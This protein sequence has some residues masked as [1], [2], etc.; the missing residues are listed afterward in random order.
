MANYMEQ[1]LMEVCAKS[2]A[3]SCLLNC[4]YARR[5]KAL[6]NNFNTT[7]CELN[8]VFLSSSGWRSALWRSSIGLSSSAAPVGEDRPCSCHALQQ[9]H[10][11]GSKKAPI[12]PFYKTSSVKVIGKNMYPHLFI[13][14]SCSVFNP[15]QVNFYADHTKIIL[16]KSSDDS[17]LLTYISRERVSYTYLLSMLNEMGCTSELRHRLRYVVQLLQHHADAWEHSSVPP[18][19]PDW[20]DALEATWLVTTSS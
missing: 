7:C 2:L 14:H 15:F 10:S 6:L 9:W 18:R 17:Y 19:L 3:F 1:N 13:L 5:R 20:A 16:C 8:Y 4:L 12:I 11:T